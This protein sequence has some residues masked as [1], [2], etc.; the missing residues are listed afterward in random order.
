MIIRIPDQHPN[1]CKN[2]RADGHDM[3]GRLCRCNLEEGH[4]GRC[5]FTF[6]KQYANSWTYKGYIATG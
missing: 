3:Y 6:L 5:E 1:R 4:E 2:L